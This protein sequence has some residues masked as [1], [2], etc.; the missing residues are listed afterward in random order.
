MSS[1]IAFAVTDRA[2]TVSTHKFAIDYNNGRAVGIEV[3]TFRPPKG[4]PP[5]TARP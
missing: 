1:Q 2:G 4:R 5:P 3:L